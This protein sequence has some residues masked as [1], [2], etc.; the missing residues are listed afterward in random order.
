MIREPDILRIDDSL[1]LRRFDGICPE[2]YSWYQAPETVWLV[3]GV[4]EPYDRE[5]L[6]RMY[7]FL[8]RH[9][10]L[11]YIEL[12]DGGG[13]FPIGDVA[14][15]E[16]DLPIVIGDPAFR[17]RG[18]GKKVV[19]RLIERGRELG[20]RTLRVREIYDY[21]KASRALFEG[22]GFREYKKTDNGAGFELVL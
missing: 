13:F 1:C 10:E 17:G 19:R 4:R 18:I 7:T 3:D 8:D 11:Y 6:S 5:K 21:N 15:G 14:F 2:A 12:D 22:C 20:Y 9:Y 16:N